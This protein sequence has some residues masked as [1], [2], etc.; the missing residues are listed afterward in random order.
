MLM[1]KISN[2][3]RLLDNYLKAVAA[4]NNDFTATFLLKAG[5][6]ALELGK[7]GC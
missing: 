7:K 4:N 6:T 3:K 2:Q 5:K 1:H